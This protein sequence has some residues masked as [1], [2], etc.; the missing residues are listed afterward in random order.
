MKIT[1]SV[2]QQKQVSTHGMRI[3]SDH[4]AKGPFCCMY[5]PFIPLSKVTAFF[6]WI[7]VQTALA[8][9]LNSEYIEYWFSGEFRDYSSIP[10]PPFEVTDVFASPR[11][12]TDGVGPPPP[13]PPFPKTLVTHW[14]LWI[15]FL[16]DAVHFL[17]A[18]EKA[19]SWKRKRVNR[20]LYQGIGLFSLR[21]IM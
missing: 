1:Y 16:I 13:A 10:G 14:T 12:Q 17:K 21:K 11:M 4:T 7:L 18:N 9:N 3:T 2:K 20:V 6:A 19:Q 15:I 5:Q 8:L